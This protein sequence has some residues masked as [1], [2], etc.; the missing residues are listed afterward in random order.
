MIRGKKVVHMEKNIG[1]LPGKGLSIVFRFAVAVDSIGQFS[2]LIID[3][4]SDAAK[5]TEISLF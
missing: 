4:K 5:T 2:L 3:K 1:W